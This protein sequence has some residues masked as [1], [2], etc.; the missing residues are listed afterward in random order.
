MLE[1]SDNMPFIRVS[2]MTPHAGKEHEVSELI[3]ALLALYRGR[4]GF[5]KAYRLAAHPAGG[6]TRMGRLSMWNSEEEIR[7]MAGNERD[8]AL[9][10]QLKLITDDETHEE[11]SF[12]AVP[13][14]D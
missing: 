4:P 5:I 11:Y 7:S 2:V 8:M 13:L 10:S 12:E 6:H 9:Q 1:A 14:P 3:D